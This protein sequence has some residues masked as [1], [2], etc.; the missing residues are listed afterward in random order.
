MVTQERPEIRV[1]C[2]R[3]E[4][5]PAG[6]A[7]AFEKLESRLSTLRGRKFFATC[8]GQDYRACVQLRDD[9]D[10]EA[11]GLEVGVV[12]GGLYA[13]RRLEGGPEKIEATF[14][15][16]AAEHAQ[17]VSRPC[18]EFYRRHDEVILFLPITS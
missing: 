16:I 1:M 6:S 14:D 5:G 17:D 7:A 11:L 18:V 12:P 3:A 9:D 8:R 4:G 10:P 13:K 2:V 15:A